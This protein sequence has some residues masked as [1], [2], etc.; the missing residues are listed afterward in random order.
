MKMKSQKP[1]IKEVFISSLV[2]PKDQSLV[3]MVYSEEQ[4]STSFVQYFNGE[5][6]ER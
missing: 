4:D 3:E 2:S 6:D 1:K 5:I